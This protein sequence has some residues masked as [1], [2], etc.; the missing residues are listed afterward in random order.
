MLQ[1][2]VA[3]GVQR[4]PDDSSY[5][6]AVIF[7]IYANVGPME[8]AEK[9]WQTYCAGLSGEGQQVWLVK[10]SDPDKIVT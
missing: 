2:L 8:I 1:R 10:S 5:G 9:D 6:V 3:A 4:H 7:D